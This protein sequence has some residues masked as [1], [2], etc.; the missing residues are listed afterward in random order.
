MT[1]VKT[2]T[3]LT[4]VKMLNYLESSTTSNYH[5]GENLSRWVAPAPKSFRNMVM[6]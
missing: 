6:L 1:H 5:A 2:F 4:L 3:P